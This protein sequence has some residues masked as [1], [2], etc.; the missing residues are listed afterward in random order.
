MTVVAITQARMTSTRLPGKVLL[1]V[2]GRPM[3]AYHVERLR[4][5][6]RIDTLV[7][8]T[9]TNATDEPIVRFCAEAGVACY[10][11]PE[12]DVLARYHGCAVAH[13]ATVVV[14]LTSDCPLIDPDIVDRC[15]A[16]FLEARPGFDYVAN[17]LGVRTY[18]RGLDAEVFSFRALDEAHREAADPAEREHV[19]PFLYRHPERYRLG[20]VAH[21]T[22][23][24]RH[25]WTLDEPA[26]FDLLSRMI[27]ALYPQRP[28]FTWLDGL[29]LLERHPEW[30]EINRAVRQKAL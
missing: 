13:G 24:S 9:T 7:V 10:R 1:P 18:P 11:G 15:I 17:T 12:D 2:L 25:R 23:Q 19:T 14:R 8:A 21:P 22:D 26:D 27:A 3:L 30:S 6:C 20:N 5:C 28:D 16:V 4:R 29:A